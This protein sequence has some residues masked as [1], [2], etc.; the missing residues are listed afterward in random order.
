MTRKEENRIMIAALKKQREEVSASKEAA[1][2]LLKKLG[3]YDMLAEMPE[4]RAAA[5]AAHEEK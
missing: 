3:I 4:N 2:A 5:A 1:R